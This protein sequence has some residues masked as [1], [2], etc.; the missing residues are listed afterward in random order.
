M[1]SI[2][3]ELK[4]PY[5][6]RLDALRFICFF[7]VFGYHSFYTEIPEIANHSTYLFLKKEVFGNGNLGVN[8]FFVLSGFLITLLLAQEKKALNT[9]RIRA[10]YTRRILRIW[11]LFFLC[12]FFGFVV[13]PFLKELFGQASTETAHW[14]SY[15]FFI[16]NFDMIYNS[17]PDA[18][19]LSVLWSVAVEEQF[20]LFWPIALYFIPQKLWDLFFITIVIGSCIF[21]YLQPGYEAEEMHTLSCM[22]D[23][24]IGALTAH[25]FFKKTF[26]YA[27]SKPQWL[28]SFLVIGGIGSVLL[29][30]FEL[31]RDSPT[32][33]VFERVVIASLASWFIVL[34]CSH[35]QPIFRWADFRTLQHLGRIS[36]GLYCLHFLGILI[37]LQFTRY[38]GWNTQLWQVLLLEFT[39]SFAITWGLAE[40][41][42]RWFEGPFLRL[43]DKFQTLVKSE[44]DHSPNFPQ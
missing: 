40:L 38:F 4:Y 41:S 34:L 32:S 12:V 1:N 28:L 3:N 2:E 31:L 15:V 14:W 44:K 13:F 39:L 11:P 37:A 22:G 10:F 18:S 26:S 36:Y 16:N 7:L 20:Y 21:R 42:Y 30:R 35:N 19:I 29:F 5:Y 43:K 27:F 9:I 24:A 33:I 17:P 8:F 6:P 25:A 23:L